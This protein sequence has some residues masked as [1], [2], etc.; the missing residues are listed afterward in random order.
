MP[1]LT[2][3]QPDSLQT[4]TGSTRWCESADSQ[5][6]RLVKYKQAQSMRKRKRVQFALEDTVHLIPT[7]A[8]MSPNQVNRLWMDDFAR[9]ENKQE[10]SNTIFL[11][12]SGLGNKLHEE[13]YFCMRGLEHLVN[14]QQKK[15]HVRHSISVA[16]AMQQFLREK[17]EVSPSM[18]ARA[19]QRAT[20][21]SKERAYKLAIHDH[22][23]STR[24]RRRPRTIFR[25]KKL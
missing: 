2:I 3:P 22:V 21:Q 7:R 18:I 19:Y 23:E 20:L 11:I 6:H 8:E 17:G 24:K 4:C 5:G 13:D 12:R 9:K 25:A 14:K 10:V 16:L 1:L 15:E